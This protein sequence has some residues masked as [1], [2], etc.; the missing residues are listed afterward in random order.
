VSSAL[1]VLRIDGPEVE[2]HRIDA[3]AFGSTVIAMADLVQDVARTNERFSEAGPVEVQVESTGPGSVVTT[4][5]II[6]IGE[7]WDLAKA[8]LTSSD[9]TATVNIVALGTVVVG[10]LKLIKTLAGRIFNPKKAPL[11][12][13]DDGTVLVELD[14]GSVIEV[15][16]DVYRAITRPAVRHS[17]RRAVRVL[18][19]PG[20]DSLAIE[21]GRTAVKVTKRDLP[22]FEAPSSSDTLAVLR[23]ELWVVPDKVRYSGDAKWGVKHDGK[24]YQVTME[25]DGFGERVSRGDVRI[26]AT[27]RFLVR[28][29]SEETKTPAGRSRVDRFIEKV[30]DQR[31]QEG[32]QPELISVEPPRTARPRP[33]GR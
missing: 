26:S 1:I 16:G 25:D 21:S 18:E 29:R 12:Y 20:I 11:K 2:E 31:I 30:L 27:D 13:Q 10:T 32:E 19:R 22:A 9:A 17:A 3:R 8:A 23:E 15:D 28:M 5:Q 24:G 7:L 6:G 14:D 33:R 4:L